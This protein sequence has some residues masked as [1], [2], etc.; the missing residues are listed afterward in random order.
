VGAT[1]PFLVRAIQDIR[2]FAQ[3]TLDEVRWSQSKLLTLI[4]RANALVWEEILGS[5]EPQTSI[6]Y[7]EAPVTI[8][9]GQ[10]D[11]LYP[12]TFRKFLRL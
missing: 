11:Y 1:D 7:T 3:D 9:A 10:E 2:D 8:T 4:D 12:G 5:R 6:R